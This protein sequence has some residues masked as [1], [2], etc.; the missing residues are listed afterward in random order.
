MRRSAIGRIFVFLYQWLP[1][2]RRFLAL[3][4]RLEGGQFYSCTL[5]T[6]LARHHGVTAGS[7]S[8]GSLLDPGYADKGTQIGSYVS[9]GPNVRRFGAAHPL[10]STSLHPFWYNSTF[11]Y[12]SDA[13]DVERTECVIGHDSWIGA[14]VTILPG[15]RRIGI[16]AVVGAGS[17]VTRDVP[18]FSIVVGN[19]GRVIGH[20]LPEDVRKILLD[21]RPWNREPKEAYRQLVEIEELLQ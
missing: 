5:R 12:V 4:T 9:I 2:K 21:A 8:Y 18:D 16:G 19:P 14:N 1:L 7:F 10:A 17:V 20:R 15:C 6:I 13:H 3:V 11:G